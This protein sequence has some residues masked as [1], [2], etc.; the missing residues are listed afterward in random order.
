MYTNVC[1][2]GHDCILITINTL[3]YPFAILK[4][5]CH[6]KTTII[7]V[8]C[9]KLRKRRVDL[10]QDYP[11]AILFNLVH[12]CPSMLLFS[13]AVFLLCC[14]TVKWLLQCIILLFVL[15][16]CHE[17]DIILRDIA[18]LNVKIP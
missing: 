14:S 9:H 12:L 10:F 3:S 11:N 15:F 18:H 4:A 7:K 5:L 16:G 17:N 13:F 2:K 6:V 8:I 1:S